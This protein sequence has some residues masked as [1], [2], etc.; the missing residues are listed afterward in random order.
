M[1]SS[2]R[3]CAVCFGDTKVIDSRYDET[4]GMINRERICLNCK[5]RYKT[6]EMDFKSYDKLNEC[7]TVIDRLG[8]L[9]NAKHN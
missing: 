3:V 5:R 6:L 4:T 8:E 7:K 2:T 1:I 9:V